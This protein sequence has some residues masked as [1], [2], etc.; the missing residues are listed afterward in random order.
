LN[1][2]CLGKPVPKARGFGGSAAQPRYCA[3]GAR[4]SIGAQN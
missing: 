3:S 2:L 4:M 1:F